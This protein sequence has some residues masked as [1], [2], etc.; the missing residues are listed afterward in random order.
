MTL[1]AR[2][3]CG[4]TIG[5]GQIESHKTMNSLF[6]ILLCFAIGATVA[7][8]QEPFDPDNLS[9]FDR[10]VIGFAGHPASKATWINEQ[11]KDLVI[12]RL[13]L[14]RSIRDYSYREE[15]IDTSLV[16]LGDEEAMLC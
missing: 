14:M 8:A 3:G 10:K 5:L 2:R 15:G 7:F 12:Q 1:G 16:S 9:D 13:K 4:K 6:Q 11:N